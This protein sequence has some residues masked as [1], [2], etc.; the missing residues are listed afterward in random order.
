MKR[1][2]GGSRGEGVCTPDKTLPEVICREFI[3]LE[4]IKIDA[5]MCNKLWSELRSRS[6]KVSG[7][8]PELLT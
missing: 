5:I 8:K 2:G 3:D 1:S 7:N 4:E 6:L